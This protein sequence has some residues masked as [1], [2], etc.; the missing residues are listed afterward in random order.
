M[1]L[2]LIIFS[3]RG[4][5]AERVMTLMANHWA[6]K[7]WRVTL[8]T[9]D[10]GSENPAY[11]LDTAVIR[12]PLG[13]EGKSPG[14]ARA[15]GANLRR[16]VVIRRAIRES[17]P[18]IV[19]SFLDRVNVRTIVA[20]CGLS[21]PVIVSE[22]VDPAHHG[23]GPLWRILRRVSYRHAS[24]VVAQTDR[25]LNYFPRAIQRK[26]HV[27]P[28][29]VSRV[30]R[31]HWVKA[32]KRAPVVVAMGRL[33]YQKGFDQLLRAFSRIAAKHPRWSLV[34]W[35]EGSA[36][37]ELE[38]LRD[39]LGLQERALLPGWTAEP[40]HEMRRGGLFVLSSRYEGFAM[41]LLEAM[42]CGL[43]VV[44]FDCPS[45]AREIVRHGVDGV[46]VPPGDVC[47]LAA[48]MDRLLGDDAER[49]R[50]ATRAVEVS[51]RFGEDR[52]MEMWE[53]VLHDAAR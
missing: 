30:V 17:D 10:D 6:A 2:T 24:C 4:G 37:G 22:R 34:I 29:A 9:Y 39:Q 18:E 14:L 27:I 53:A 51:A 48:A 41:V 8:L 32:G 45:G 52:V 44:S 40:F 13:I 15:L 23:V 7:G 5:G 11:R 20:C 38:A 50:L 26:G 36:R 19:I 25:A 12:R 3:L 31:D 28:N 43:P 33:A 46:L 21:A 35:G 16:I 42:A 49:N 47:A 1:R